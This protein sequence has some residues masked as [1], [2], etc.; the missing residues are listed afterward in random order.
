MNS[1]NFHGITISEALKAELESMEKSRRMPHAIIISGG[2]GQSRESLS[3]HLA[4]W[5]VCESSQKPCGECR[6]CIK[7]QSKN[8]MDIYYAKGRGK[9][10]IIPVDEVRNIIKDSVIVPGEA[11]KKVYIFYDADKR[12]AKE[13][14]N[15]FLKT[16]EEPTQDTLFI[17]TAES[18]KTLPVTIISRCAVLNISAKESIPEDTLVLAREILKG[19]IALREMELMKACAALS[20]RQKALEVLPVIRT[21]LSDALS[22]SVGAE[23]LCDAETATLLRQKLTKAKI[24]SLIDVTSNAINKTNRNVNPTILT[25]WLCGEYRRISWQK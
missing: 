10:D 22:L 3:R 24:I 2:D 6:A 17:L 11:H 5:A 1:V 18:A 14:Y 12:M 19:I 21:V 8:H 16:L 4:M 25:T 20:S 13:G 23:P 7:A 15:A 9:T